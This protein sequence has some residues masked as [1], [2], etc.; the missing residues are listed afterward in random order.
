MANDTAKDVAA[1]AAKAEQASADVR[2]LMAGS[3]E[4]IIITRDGHFAYTNP[5]ALR[6][7]GYRDEEELFWRPLATVVHANDR[8]NVA[9]HLD[10]AVEPPARPHQHELRMVRRTGQVITVMAAFLRAD[11]DGQP[12]VVVFVHD[13]TEA[14]RMEKQLQFTDRMASVGTLAAGVAHEINNPLTYVLANLDL[15]EDEMQT[16]AAAIGE[17]S[18]N[19]LRGLIEEAREGAFRVRSIVRELRVFAR[20]DEQK[21]VPVNLQRMIES[22]SKMAMNE[23][24]HRAQFVTDF[25]TTPVVH[26]N[27]NHLSQVMLNLLVN[28]A[29]AIPTGKVEENQVRVRTGTDASG[30]AL[31]E[32]A[33]TGVGIGFDILDRIFDPFFTT[34]DPGVGTGLGLSICHSLITAMGGQIKVDSIVGEGTTFRITLPSSEADPPKK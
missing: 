18:L 26:A 32:V 16:R 15:M 23:I 11:Y 24:R 34:K 17:D 31:I 27:P 29:H 30:K 2:T 8:P 28:A 7:L 9:E 21:V 13:V 20:P 25:A 12:A 22:V 4:G 6:T 33:D 14:R 3:P 10:N 1:A 5:A 19:E